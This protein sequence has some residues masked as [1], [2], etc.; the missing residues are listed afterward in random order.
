VD[1]GQQHVQCPKGKASRS[2]KKK[3][4]ASGGEAIRVRFAMADCGVCE[5][6]ALCTHSKQRPRVLQLPQQEQYEALQAAREWATSDHGK[7]LYARRAGLEGPL[8]QGVRAYGLRRSRYRGL[9]KTHVQHV[10]TAVAINV[11][12]I[13]AWLDDRPQATTRTS[14]FAAL[15]PKAA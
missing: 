13:V 10:A 6:R 5:S 7:Q 4:L 11:D 8:S 3:T 9:A 1:W 2:W 14:R 12:R 15:Q